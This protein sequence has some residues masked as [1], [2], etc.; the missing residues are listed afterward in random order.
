MFPV[1]EDVVHRARVQSAVGGEMIKVG[2]VVMVVRV[3]SCCG[4]AESLGRTFR[5]EAIRET[6]GRCVHCGHLAGAQLVADGYPFHPYQVHRLKR[7]QPPTLSEQ[8]ETADT[9]EIK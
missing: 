3:M 2:D 5:V 4:A 1:W 7:L 8:K 9:L 6:L